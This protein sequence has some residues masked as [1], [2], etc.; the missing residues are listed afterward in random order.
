MIAIQTTVMM[1]VGILLAAMT[2]LTVLLA[3]ALG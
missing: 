3:S 1:R 2:A